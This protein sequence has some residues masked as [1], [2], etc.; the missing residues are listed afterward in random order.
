MQQT[1]SIEF[2]VVPS[3]PQH[4]LSLTVEL[5]GQVQWQQSAVTEKSHVIIQ[6]DDSQITEHSIKLIVANKTP[7]HTKID[8]EGNIIDDS[9]LILD[10]ILMSDID[11]TNFCHT[12]AT[13]THDLNGTGAM[14]TQPMY[15][16]LGCNGTAEMKF[17]TPIYLWLLEHI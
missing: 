16:E 1:T 6:L 8:S 11:V 3:K 2:D 17:T 12:F 9:V 10:N 14:R 7:E 5:N 4:P 15:C 13:Y